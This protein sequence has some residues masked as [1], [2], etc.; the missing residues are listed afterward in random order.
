[1]VDV[2]G[3]PPEMCR[4][5]CRVS[6]RVAAERRRPQ[7]AKLLIVWC[8][9]ADS[10][11]EAKAA[12][13][14]VGIENWKSRPGYFRVPEA[15]LYRVLQRVEDPVAR[16]LFVGPFASESQNSY[17]HGS[18]G[19][20]LASRRIEVLRAMAIGGRERAQGYSSK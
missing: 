7:F 15:H 11:K 12:F 1:V 9:E 18:G 4:P 14:A 20:Y 13:A 8:P 6:D 5:L 19:R 16:I 3:N 2:E 10:A 17:I